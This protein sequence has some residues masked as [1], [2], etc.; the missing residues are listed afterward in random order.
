MNRPTNPYST[1]GSVGDTASFVGRIELLGELASLVRRPDRPVVVLAGAPGSGRTSLLDE[2]VGY[3]EEQGDLRPVRFDLASHA[4]GSLDDALLHLGRAVSSALELTDPELGGWAEQRFTDNYLPTVLST[5]SPGERLVLLLDEYPIIDDPRTRQVRGSFLPWLGGVL[6]RHAAQISVLL[7]ADPRLPLVEIALR[8]NLPGAI[9][10]RIGSLEVGQAWALVRLSQADRSLLWSNEAVQAVLEQSGGHPAVTQAIC[11]VVWDR[12]NGPNRPVATTTPAMV[13]A[14]LPAAME[15]MS[16]IFAAT[17]ASLSPAARVA[18]GVIAAQEDPEPPTATLGGL[19]RA[20]GIQGLGPRLEID[21]P[22]ELR[23][24]DV[25]KAEPERLAFNIPLF[26]RWLREARTLEEVLG[27]L[28]GLHPEAD[29]LW[30]LA[31]QAWQSARRPAERLAA[32]DDIRRVLEL[33]PDHTGAIEMLAAVCLRN[34]DLHGAIPYLERLFPLRPLRAGPYLT[35]TLLDLAERESSPDARLP[36]YDRVL[37]LAPGHQEARRLRG[38]LLEDRAAQALAAGDLASAR[39]SAEITDI[40]T[41]ASTVKREVKARVAEEA[42]KEIDSRIAQQDYVGALDAARK[43]PSVSPE[44]LARLEEQAHLEVL[45]TEGLAALNRGD[46]ERAARTFAQIVSVQPNFRETTRFLHQAVSGQDP[47]RSPRSR[48]PTSL[49]ASVL[50]LTAAIT[51]AWLLGI[52]SPLAPPEAIEAQSPAALATTLP[53]AQPPAPTANP[54][55][56]VAPTSEPPA[57]PTAIPAEAPAP[58]PTPAE[59]STSIPER[60]L[61]GAWAAVDAGEWEAARLLFDRALREAP[62]SADAHFGLGYVADERGEKEMAVNHYC[63]AQSFANRDPRL[64][65]RIQGRLDRIGQ[66][67]Y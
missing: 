56:E 67:C 32:V 48:L 37:E 30:R 65:E 52:P 53:P 66:R 17:W 4:E 28:D 27:E 22:R 57:E 64:G 35:R 50:G 33:N 7:V 21:A 45:Y 44:E 11:E 62:R 5:L 46:R 29:A 6:E 16:G 19:L 8:K 25:L 34:K 1:R 41:M 51:I 9:H 40:P 61:Q 49:F 14:A 20:R 13:Q 58:S 38:R 36:L 23:A 39:R 26:R 10:R 43:V 54:A 31:A 63:K 42:R 15:L 47:V 55:G 12:A 24:Q 59:T 2:L 60:S 18:L 3:L